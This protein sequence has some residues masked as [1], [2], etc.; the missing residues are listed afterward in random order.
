ILEIWDDLSAGIII[1][2]FKKCGISNELDKTEDD[3]LYDSDKE[4]SDLDNNKD[5]LEKVDEDSL[6]AKELELED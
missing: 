5:S 4:N 6:F 1:K 2:S 3:L